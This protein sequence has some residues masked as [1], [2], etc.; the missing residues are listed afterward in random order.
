MTKK[1]RIGI[2]MRVVEAEGYREP[3]D[4]LAQDWGTFMAKALPDAS[5][6]P[7]PNLGAETVALAESWELNGLIFS[8]GNDLGQSPKRDE[9]EEALLSWAQDKNVPAFGVCRGLQ[10]F[11]RHL[12]SAVSLC[13]EHSGR[14]H[15]VT[16]TSDSHLGTFGGHTLTVNSYHNQCVKKVDLGADAIVLAEASDGSVEALRGQN[17]NFLAV[18]WHPERQHDGPS[19]LDQHLLNL[20]FG[21]ED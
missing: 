18:M 13:S 7:L 4:A 9:T 5:W 1:K 2:T 15:E 11:A 20:S 16:L 6:M 19:A 17:E 21:G 3:R 8:G 14:A 10:L 12:G